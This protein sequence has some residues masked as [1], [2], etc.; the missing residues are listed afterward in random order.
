MSPWVEFVVLD[1][2]VAVCN[3]RGVEFVVAMEGEK[4]DPMIVV[5]VVMACGRLLFLS[6]LFL[7]GHPSFL[8]RSATE[9]GLDS[10]QKEDEAEAAVVGLFW[11]DVGGG[12]DGGAMSV[13]G[14]EREEIVGERESE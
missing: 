9:S 13:G 14:K 6:L 7:F 3:D 8:L 4:S 2:V 5:T 1:V 10:G 11:M 12:G